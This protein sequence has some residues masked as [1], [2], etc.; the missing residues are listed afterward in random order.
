[1]T[2]RAARRCD[3]C[4]L[5]AGPS[6][7][8]SN[9]R[10]F[11]CAGCEAVWN[12]LHEEGLGRFYDA[13]GTGSLAPRLAAEGKSPAAHPVLDQIEAAGE[14]SL[15]VVGMR[16]ASCA[17]LIERYLGRR[18]GVTDVRAS[19]A[20]STCHVRWDRDRTSLSHLLAE[21]ERIGYR[22]R[23]ADARLSDAQADREGRRLA[24]RTGIS[25]L[26]AMNVMLAAVALYAGEFQGIGP[27]VRGTLRWLSGLLAAP[28][29]LHGGWPFFRGAV[30]ALRA[31]RA[32]MDTL[33]AL[34]AGAAFGASVY[35]LATDG[36][37]YFDTAAMIVALI[38]GGRLLEH[39]ARRRG[40]RA[41]RNL[42]ALEPAA[43]HLVTPEGTATVAADALSA[44]QIV[45]VRPGERIPVDGV[46]VNGR[47][48]VEEAVLTGEPAPRDVASG[49]NVIAGSFNGRGLLRVRAAKV[50]AETVVAGIHRAVRRALGTKAPVEPLA[51]RAMEWF[52]PGVL[53]LALATG[54]IWDLA[55][56]GGGR[57]LLVAVA[58]V[59]IACPCALGLA[60][61]AA[62][63]VALGR[64]AESGIFF[65][66]AE[67]LERAGS[68][69]GVALDKTGTLTDGAAG[70]RIRPEAADAVRDLA[71]D[72]IPTFLLTGDRREPAIAAG[73]AAGI[74]AER[75]RAELA[76]EA[77]MQAL[78]RLRADRVPVAMVG[79]GVNDAPALATADLGVAL[80]TGTDIA[81]E[82]ADVA[83]RTADL[84][85]VPRALA[86]ARRT[87][88]V[89]RQNLG[90]AIGYNAI[91]IPLAAVG[92]LHPVV[93]AGAMALSSL[94]VLA[95]S[96]RLARA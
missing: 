2:T 52:V 40:T 90:W 60:T 77:K 59:V 95:N 50:G 94:S 5:D 18:T 15:D 32:T 22:A 7:R 71:A 57:A 89:V 48:N 91:A 47:S 13:G 61:P 37:V 86:L 35:G 6:P 23:P 75:V 92:L 36:A 74:P 72:G 49:S 58:V 62:L 81:L 4:G 41:I 19:Y 76:P 43:A 73:H 69:G 64:A 45:E 8:Q 30:T 68:I 42:L 56:A 63:A 20:T 16:C 54:L 87:R 21:L 31:R 27:G 1:M 79:D 34:G 65:R 96:F 11:C 55:G 29:V 51:D 12:V 9:G 3:H 67:A 14:A 66:T 83:L 70:D 88:R 10:V 53:L 93:A 82:T 44:G 78:A 26:L 33:V 84:R 39:S 38:L 17:W 25:A 85:Q 24:A 46:V 28:V 80:G